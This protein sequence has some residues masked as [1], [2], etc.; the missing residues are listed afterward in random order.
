M[1]SWC[2]KGAALEWQLCKTP[3]H[4]KHAQ[5][6]PN[7]NDEEWSSR[8]IISILNFH[9]VLNYRYGEAG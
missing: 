2:S 3:R 6:V 7:S 1:S 9:L 4:D 5:N 8:K